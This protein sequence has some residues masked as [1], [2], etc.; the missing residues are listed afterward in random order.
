MGACWYFAYAFMGTI[1]VGRPMTWMELA[2]LLGACV[3]ITS[4]AISRQM[5]MARKRSPWSLVASGL[6]TN[7]VILYLIPGWVVGSF[8]TQCTEV[9]GGE[10]VVSTRVDVEDVTSSLAIWKPD[11]PTVCRVGGVQ[12]NPY[13]PGTLYRQTWNGSIHPA[14]IVFLVLV[15]MMASL[16]L[17]DTRLRKTQLASKLFPLLRF[18][19]AAGV[20]AS[21]GKPAPNMV[22]GGVVACNNATLW[23][24]TCGQI[25]ST[26]KVWVTG[27]WCLRC[28]QPFNKFPK[29]VTFKVVSLFTADVDVLNGIERMDTVSWPRGE[30]IAPDARISGEERWVTLG[31]VTLPAVITVAQALALINQLIPKWAGSENPRVKRAATIAQQRASRISCWFWYGALSHRL[32]YARPSTATVLGIGPQ[33]LSDVLVDGGEEIWLQLD[34]GL[35]PLELRTGFKKTFIEESR[36]PELQNSKFDLWIPVANPRGPKSAKGLWVPRVEG[37]AFRLWLSTDRLRDARI[38]GVT[39]PLPYLRYNP[40]ERGNP[41][42]DKAPN[43]GSLDFVRFPLGPSG[44]EPTEERA[45]GA[46]TLEWDWFEWEQIQLLRQQCLVLEETA[47]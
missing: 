38:K 21:M 27:E 23:G 44:M 41:G 16:G 3:G 25:Y 33:R 8:E 19:P 24:E 35:L 1:T 31:T 30:P 20:K 10:V 13:M 28:Q 5:F 36:K 4:W 22:K 2:A 40:D 15:S 26:E 9:L 17:R 14:M 29:E 43:E 12:D 6:V 37:D 11:G 7:V 42:S 18:A 34:I 47:R 45:I 46:S 39:I 32:T